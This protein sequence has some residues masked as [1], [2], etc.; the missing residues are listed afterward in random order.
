M[1]FYIFF[2][3]HQLMLRG[4][5]LPLIPSCAQNM[6]LK[7]PN[8]L[9]CDHHLTHKQARSKGLASTPDLQAAHCGSQTSPLAPSLAIGYC[10]RANEHSRWKRFSVWI[11]LLRFCFYQT[12]DKST[13]KI[14]C[15]VK[16]YNHTIRKLNIITHG[17]SVHNHGEKQSLLTFKVFFCLFVLFFNRLHF[18]VHF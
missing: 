2:P 12:T 18:L 8:S 11:T 15:L 6:L 14:R 13:A 1:G 7:L 9:I 10:L 3:D 4:F 17:D 5:H 16:Q